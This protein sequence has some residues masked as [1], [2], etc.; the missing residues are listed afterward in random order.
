MKN[1]MQFRK[2]GGSCQLV[3]AKAENLEQILQ[4]DEAYWAVTAMPVEAAITDPEFLAFLDSDG[5]KRIRPAE[6]KSAITWLISLLRDYSGI[7]NG[8]DVLSLDALNPE[9]AEGPVLLSA[10]KLVLE[11]LGAEDKTHLSLAQIRDKK[12]IIAAGNS[13]GDGIITPCNT[14]DPMLSACI[15][16]IITCCGSKQDLSGQPGIDAEILDAFI[17]NGSEHL[18]WLKT[19][20]DE[21][22]ASPYGDRAVDFYSLYA[23]LREKINEFFFFCGGMVDD[24]SRFGATTQTDPLNTDA[25]QTFINKAPVAIPVQSALLS[26]NRWINPNWKDRLSDFFALARE[27]NMIADPAVLTEPEWRAIEKSFAVRSSW[28]AQKT[29]DNFDSLTLEQLEQYLAEETV[30]RLRGML[31]DDLSV[32]G[33]IAACEQLRKLIL[34]QQHMLEF[35]N[36]FV[37]L[38]RLFDPN[39]LSMIQPG[40]LTMDGRH[41]T[42]ASSVTNLAEHKKIV[43][44]SDICV[45]YLELSTGTA[46]KLRKMTLAV[47][48]TS[49]TMRNIFVGKHGVYLTADNTEWDAKIIDLVQQP[50]SFTEAL[51]TPFYR[52]GEFVGKQADRFFSAKVQNMESDVTKT[53]TQ[54]A[55]AKPPADPTKQQTPA[56]SGSMMLMGGGVGLA[57]LGSSVAFIA[58]SLKNVSLWNVVAV[59]AG[60]IL[61]ISG[62]IMLVSVIKLL[63]RCVSDFFAASGWA[64]NPKMRLSRKMGRLFTYRPKFPQSIFLKGDIVELFSRDFNRRP[65]T[66]FLVVLFLFLLLCG[67]AAGCWLFF[68]FSC[69]FTP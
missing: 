47:A 55:N 30:S 19:G 20:R 45:M 41:F 31:T 17:K 43:Q 26:L 67:I 64:I 68:H 21:A 49:G 66:R 54:A 59:F 38:D 9:H 63:N 3:L 48:I 4:L 2:I 60:I 50:V 40:V 29:D 42:L 23:V 39:R 27:L 16:D 8:S 7:D 53:V 58:N 46:D 44:R 12:S 62:P 51:Q 6:L 36:N 37:T 11:N 22:A 18:K 33:E 52:F 65:R 28:Y 5:N 24:D 25:M 13:N 35:V 69:W 61:I 32:A 10:A 15:N 14:Q 56:V 34:F 1:T 57:A